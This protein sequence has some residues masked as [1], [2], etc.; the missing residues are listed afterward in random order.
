MIDPYSQVYLEHFLHPR[1]VGVLDEYTHNAHCRTSKEGCFDEVEV[2]LL[3]KNDWIVNASFRGRL[4]SG[5]ISAMSL[6]LSLCV[7]HSVQEAIQIDETTL[8]N[9]WEW[10]PPSKEHSLELAVKTVRLAI[11]RCVD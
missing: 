11:Q 1:F 4:C 2:R 5:S 8:A 3:I 10:I 7:K 9:Y 6:C